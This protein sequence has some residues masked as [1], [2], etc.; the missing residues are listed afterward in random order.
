MRKCSECGIETGAGFMRCES[1]FFK[2]TGFRHVGNG[3]YLVYASARK[4]YY[5]PVRYS[6]YI[7]PYIIH[8]RYIYRTGLF[9][10]SY[11]HH[12]VEKNG[13]TS[14]QAAKLLAN[15]P[16]IIKLDLAQRMK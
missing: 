14:I 9:M 15:N 1:C 12:K 2:F 10:F 7:Y 8:K 16:E 11:P 6:I 13:L 5:D 4:I 3:F